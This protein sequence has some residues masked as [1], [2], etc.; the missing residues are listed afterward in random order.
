M[1]DSLRLVSGVRELYV[2]S[3]LT[4][5]VC[6]PF[7]GQAVT[8][9]HVLL[10]QLPT[11]AVLKSNAIV[12]MKFDSDG[13]IYLAGQATDGGLYTAKY[14]WGGGL[15]WSNH[16]TGALLGIVPKAVDVDAAGS[17]YVAA[18]CASN[19]VTLKQNP[20]GSPAWTNIV[21]GVASSDAPADI[22]V[23]LSGNVYVA[24]QLF[25]P[26]ANAVAVISYNSYG[27]QRWREDGNNQGAW[28]NGGAVCVKVDNRGHVFVGEVK[29]DYFPS[30]SACCY[31]SV[32]TISADNGSVSAPWPADSSALA[33]GTVSVPSAMGV[34]SSGEVA[35]VA[36]L[37]GYMSLAPAYLSLWRFGSNQNAQFTT[38]I[39]TGAYYTSIKSVGLDT[40]GSIYVTLKSDLCKYNSSGQLWSTTPTA[41][42]SSMDV[43]PS[44]DVILAESTSAGVCIVEEYASD[45][46]LRW[47][48][49]CPNAMTPQIVGLSKVKRW[50]IP[51]VS[52]DLRRWQVAGLGAGNSGVGPDV[53]VLFEVALDL[54]DPT[55]NR[56]AIAKDSASSNNVILSWTSGT[57][58]ETTNLFDGSWIP[59]PSAS[60]FTNTVIGPKK[61]YRLN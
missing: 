47:T 41:T 17:L 24:G 14:S 18:N 6:C 38:N 53:F 56:V 39:R 33:K 60:P 59:N 54:A 26:S 52:P 27:V 44:G 51:G 42:P 48:V 23:D 43:Y 10:S 25:M 35:C 11:S 32:W 40:N 61:F 50:P 34:N 58:I 45:S 29:I 7:V 13:A 30:S 5:L 8:S 19:W 1:K 31:Y 12:K 46:T 2:L 22:A 55:T 3:L 36:Y 16:F 57:L 37:C 20:N 4:G 49:T 28:I 21:T 9:D 15:E